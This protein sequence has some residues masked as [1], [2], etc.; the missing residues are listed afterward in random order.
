MQRQA[1]VEVLIPRDLTTLTEPEEQK[2]F[3]VLCT[4]PLRQLRRYQTINEVQ[5]KLAAE[6]GN[7]FVLTNEQV[8]ADFLSAAIADK[9]SRQPRRRS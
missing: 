7:T 8:K 1:S 9:A 4:F 3:D 6:Q 5:I 2:V